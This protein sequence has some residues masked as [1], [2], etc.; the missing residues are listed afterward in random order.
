IPDHDFDRSP[1]MRAIMESGNRW[2]EEVVN[3]LLKGRAYVADGDGE[4]NKRRF[5]YD[6]TVSLLRSARP[7]SFIYQATLRPTPLFYD[8]HGLE[9]ALVSFS[10]NPLDLISVLE[11]PGGRLFRVIDVKRGTTLQLAYRVQVLLYA[12]QLQAILREGGIADA[13]VDLERAGVW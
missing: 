8:A 11:A 13:R 5:P 3:R 1:L 10:D 6:E 2:E 12:L 9:P 7:G 4:L